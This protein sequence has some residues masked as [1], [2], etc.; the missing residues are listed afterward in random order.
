MKIFLRKKIIEKRFDKKG[1][2]DK[3]ETQRI[4]RKMQKEAEEVN[5]NPF[6]E[7]L[8]NFK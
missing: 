4:M 1:K 7:L 3:R 8:K 6:A 2:I 5:D